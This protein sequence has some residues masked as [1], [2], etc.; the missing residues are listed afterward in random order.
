M[1]IRGLTVAD[2]DRIITLWS[3]A[4]LDYK[5]RGRDSREAIAGQVTANPDFLIGAFLGNRLV[6]VVVLSSDMRRGWINRLAVDPECRHRG[7]ARALIMESE[8]TLRKHGVR[9]FCSLIDDSNVASRELFKKCGYVE[10][11]DILYFSKRDDD[12]V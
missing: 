1:E 4:D 10:H 8:K 7:V 9:I 12:T 11:S 3:R 6:G 2:Y 5:P